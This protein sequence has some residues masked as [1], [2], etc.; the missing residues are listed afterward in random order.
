[1][2]FF[3]TLL[4]DWL[5]AGAVL[6]HLPGSRSPEATAAQVAFRSAE[7]QL[8]EALSSCGS[9]KELINQGFAQDV[10]LA[11]SLQASVTAPRLA[12]GAYVNAA[13]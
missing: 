6:A 5:G 8:L 9:G 1:A 3:S 11:A 7:S 10:R 12:G 4:E 13:S 2:G